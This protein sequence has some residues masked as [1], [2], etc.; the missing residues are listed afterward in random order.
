MPRKAVA[1]PWPPPRATTAGA[2]RPT[3]VAEEGSDTGTF[4]LDVA[5]LDARREAEALEHRRQLRGEHHAPVPSTGA[6]D[7]DREVR[8]PSRTY[9]GSSNANR[10]RSSS[11]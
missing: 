7:A 6:A 4:P 9:A 10:L 3:A 11:R 1:R 8:L 2:E 5:V